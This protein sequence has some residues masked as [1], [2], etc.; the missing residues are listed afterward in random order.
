MSIGNLSMLKGKKD[1][2]FRFG[3]KKGK[4]PGKSVKIDVVRELP[5]VCAILEPIGGVMEYITVV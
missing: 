3:R 1:K 2:K 4:K 5:A